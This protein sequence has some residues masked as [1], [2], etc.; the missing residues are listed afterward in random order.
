[1]NITPIEFND[2]TG[3]IVKS[4]LICADERFKKVFG[5]EGGYKEFHIT[6]LLDEEGRAIYP[7]KV[8]KCSFCKD[9]KPKGEGRVRI[10]DVAYF[11]VS[12]KKEW[13]TSLFSYTSCSLSIKGIKIDIESVEVEEEEIELG[14][15]DGIFIKFRGPAV[16]RDPWHR[17]GGEL[18]S[19]F[20]P[21]PSHLFSTNVYSLFREK[22]FEVL[23]ELEKALV[24]DHSALNSLGKVWYYYGGKWLPALSGSIIFWLREMNDIVKHTLLHASYFGVGSGRAAGF[25]DIVLNVF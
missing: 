25:G 17:P 2:F 6:P 9:K 15:G 14:D 5:E 20:L 11:E 19:R 16:L 13:L 18:R 8:V 7:R 24:E 1:M 23:M 3:K 4:F 12:G 10:P 21:S 22:Y